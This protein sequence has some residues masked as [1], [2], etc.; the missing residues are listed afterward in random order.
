MT[1]GKKFFR[2]HKAIA[3]QVI[4]LENH[5]GVVGGQLPL[6]LSQCFNRY[7]CWLYFPP[8]AEYVYPGRTM[9]DFPAFFYHVGFGHPGKG[10]IVRG[11]ATTR[12]LHN[13]ANGQAS[14]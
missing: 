2:I 3:K 13:R 10:W 14:T 1:A 12:T 8:A 11:T 6:L 5:L 7:C 4:L 9:S